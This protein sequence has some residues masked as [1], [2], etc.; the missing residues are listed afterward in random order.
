MQPE[1]HNEI[2]IAGGLEEI[3]GEMKVYPEDREVQ[4]CGCEALGNLVKSSKSSD[5]ADHIV[6]KLE[7]AHL[8]G[9]VMKAFPSFEELQEKACYALFYFSVYRGVQASIK[10]AAGLSALGVALE[11]FPNNNAIQEHGCATMKRLLE[12]GRAPLE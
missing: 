1:Y 4:Y 5:Q 12:A 8:I 3:A 9:A 6:N 10:R 11:N 7:G 2:V